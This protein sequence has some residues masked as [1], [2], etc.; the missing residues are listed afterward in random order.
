MGKNLIL[1]GEFLENERFCFIG[2]SLKIFTYVR[3][4]NIPFEIMN[5][6]YIKTKPLK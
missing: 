6:V 2:V 3:I 5:A 4:I 1:Y